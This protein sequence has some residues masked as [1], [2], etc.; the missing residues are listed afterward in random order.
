[1]HSVLFSCVDDTVIEM[2][3]GACQHISNGHRV[4]IPSIWHKRHSGYGGLRHRPVGSSHVFSGDVTTVWHR[5]YVTVAQTSATV[6]TD[7]EAAGADARGARVSPRFTSICRYGHCLIPKTRRTSNL[8]PILFPIFFCQSSPI[9]YLLAPQIFTN[10]FY[11]Q[12]TAWALW[13]QGFFSVVVELNYC[14]NSKRKR[15]KEKEKGGRGDWTWRAQRGTF[16]FFD[17]NV[18]FP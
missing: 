14:N 10:L 2:T 1:M 7:G 6:F 12:K 17:V 11:R 8:L 18:V 5:T 16:N 4:Y 13:Q 3:P 15:K 9:F